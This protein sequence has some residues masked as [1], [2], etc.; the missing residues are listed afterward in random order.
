MTNFERIVSTYNLKSTSIDE[1]AD[2]ILGAE[3]GE[4]NCCVHSENGVCSIDKCKVG[5]AEWLKKEVI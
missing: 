3:G 2:L 1:V 5:V 4:C